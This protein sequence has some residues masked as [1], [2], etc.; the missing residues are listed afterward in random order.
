MKGKKMEKKAFQGGMLIDGTGKPPVQDSLVV[1]EGNRITYVGKQKEF[2]IPKGEKVQ[3]I[4]GKGRTIM[5]GLIDGHLHM[6]IIGQSREF[7]SIPIHNNNIDIAMKAIPRL[8]NML[9]MGF[10]TVRDG[11]GG[12]GW[13]EVSL[14]EAI[15]R[16]DI[17]GPRYLATGY[18]LT[19]SGGHGYFLPHW[20]GKYAPP[21]QNGMHCDGPDEWRKAARLNL[22]NGTDCIKLVASRGFLSAGL[23][24][25]APPTGAPAT[26]E[27][28]RAAVEEGHKMGKKVF[29][30]ANG[31]DAI[32][33]AVMAGVD[34]I[35]HGW[36]M[37]EECL[38]MMVKKNAVLEPTTLCIKLVRDQGK[39]EMLDVMV[40]RAAAYWERKQKEFEMIRKSGVTISMAT[41]AGVPYFYHGDN[42]RELESMVD[43]GLSPMEAILAATKAAANTIGLRDEI[44]SLEKGKKADIILV[45][46]NPLKNIRILQDK[47]KIKMV[48]KDGKIVVER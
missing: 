21:E 43:L 20:L 22:Y 19:V 17:V 7:Y 15:K 31:H 26:I 10:T 8:K 40:E 32:M 48:M 37:D 3:I 34:S 47:R 41:D 13:F 4:E 42:A 6:G 18:H 12:F 44:G 14:R 2:K 27:E 25:D 24:G 5:P 29:A 45:D 30:H 9:E 11:G 38:E 46:G 16:G 33:N 1:T 23:R 35:V 28:M 39:G 36:Y